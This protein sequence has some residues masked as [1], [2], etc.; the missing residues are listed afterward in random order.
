MK[1]IDIAKIVEW[2]VMGYNDYVM[3]YYDDDLEWEKE[4][5]W[6]MP[7]A[8]LEAR[9]SLIVTL[10][11]L[12]IA[13]ESGRK[14]EVKAWAVKLQNIK[15]GVQRIAWVNFNYDSTKRLCHDYYDGVIDETE[16]K[17][18]II[19]CKVVFEQ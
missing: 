12:K 13:E 3:N 4:P 9:N 15:S 2:L 8:V 10:D 16:E 14:K 6:R 11:N 1:V 18:E 17:Y 5:L 7:R 19:P